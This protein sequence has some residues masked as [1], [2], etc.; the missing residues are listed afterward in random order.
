MAAYT[1]SPQCLRGRGTSRCA[2]TPGP[3]RQPGP[4]KRG[5]TLGVW[6]GG[7]G[8]TERTPLGRPAATED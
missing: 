6:R 2:Q 4:R 8:R 7:E 5:A 3:R 1:P